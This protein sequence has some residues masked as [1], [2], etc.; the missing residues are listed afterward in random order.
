MK[1]DTGKRIFLSVA[2]AVVA[3]I[4][5]FVLFYFGLTPKCPVFQRLHIYCGGCGATRALFY[6]LQ[7]QFSTAFRYNLLFCLAFPFFAFWA[8]QAWLHYC[9]Q[10]NIL[11]T[12]KFS[13]KTGIFLIVLFIAFML[14][15]N[16]PFWPFSLL[17]PPQI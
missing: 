13:R 16:L 5:F 4:A 10:K 2:I 3:I 17:A 1:F 8:I 15:R 12:L 9:F 7:G 6:L 14:L 11:P